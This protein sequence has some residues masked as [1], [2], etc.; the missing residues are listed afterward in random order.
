MMTARPGGHLSPTYT[1]QG[2][3]MCAISGKYDTNIF[4]L[5]PAGRSPV[6]V[7][8]EWGINISPTVS[9]DGTQMAYVSNRAGGPQIYVSSV[10]GGPA[11]RQSGL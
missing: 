11:R 7:T 9:P 2:N 6:Q 5:D 1:P 10:S 4:V 8:R 3:V